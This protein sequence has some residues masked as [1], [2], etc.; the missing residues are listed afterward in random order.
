M[1]DVKAWLGL[2]WKFTHRVAKEC[3]VWATAGFFGFC[4]SALPAY[5]QPSDIVM[6]MA[7]NETHARAEQG[8]FSYSSAERSTR[9]DGHLWD[10]N[11][12]EIHDGVFRRLIAIDG[13]PLTPA[14]SN[15]EEDRILNLVTHPEDF[16]RLNESRRDDEAHA[17]QLLQLLPKAFL[18][19]PTGEEDG[20]ARFAFRPDPAFHPS[21]YEERVI[22][23]MEGTVSVKEPEYRLC[24]LQATITQPVE[25]GYGFLGRLNS[26]GHFSLQ[27]SSIDATNWKTI[28]ISVHFDGKIL[29]LKSLSQNLE[30]TR[31]QIRLLPRQLTLTQA[32]QLSLP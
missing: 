12:V 13:R 5:S 25:F 10:E 16:R 29:F 20:C 8:L 15:A 30:T 3:I 22:H 28:R 23:A 11:V 1:C 32:A 4:L 17:I 26:G 27:R 14:E 31:T 7:A 19:S 6:R 21:S 18:I 2:L 24:K 9:T